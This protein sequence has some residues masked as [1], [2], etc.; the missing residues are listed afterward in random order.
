MNSSQKCTVCHKHLAAWSFEYTNILH[1]TRM[2][3]LCL[4]CWDEIAKMGFTTKKE[5]KETNIHAL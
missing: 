5:P 3:Y 2:H 1:E 4:V